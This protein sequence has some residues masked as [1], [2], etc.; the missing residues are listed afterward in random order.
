MT[1]PAVPVCYRHPGR[2]T[3]VTCNRCGRPICPDCM[4]EASV[5]F[6]CPECVHAGRR[7]QRQP[8]TAF[9]GTRAGYAGYVTIALIALNVVGLLAGALIAGVPAV[10][11]SGLFTGVT[12]LQMM[13][14]SFAPTYEIA[15]NFVPPGSQVGEVYTGIDDGAVYRLVT[16]MF[17]HYG[18]VHLL[19]NMWALWMLGRNLEAALGPVRFLAL[20]LLSGLGGSIAAYLFSPGSITA[21]ASGAIFGMFAALFVVLKRLRRDTSSVVPVLVINLVLTFTIPN[22]SIAGHLGGLLV[23]ALVAA[24]LAYAPRQGRTPVQ[25]ATIAGVAVVLAMLVVVGMVA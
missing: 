12:K 3:Y 1:A 24:G 5:G 25:V 8:L 18:I 6:Q 9:G 19:L 17:I 15:S 14:G 7:T 11:G 2:E 16:A 4:T 23:G 21:G 13:F 10:L 20:Y 22:I